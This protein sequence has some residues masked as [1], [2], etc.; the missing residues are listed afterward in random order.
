MLNQKTLAC[1]PETKNAAMA[2]PINPLPIAVAIEYMKASPDF[3][4][5]MTPTGN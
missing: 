3:L 5:P 2:K 4:F 1:I